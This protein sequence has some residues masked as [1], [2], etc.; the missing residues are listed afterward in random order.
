M[1][2]PHNWTSILV[3]AVAAWLFGAVYYTLL[4]P[5]WIA[6]QGMTVERHKAANASISR[7]AFF[8]PFV[9]SFIAE[10][11]MA[12]VLSGIMV[13]SGF[14]TVRQG[15]IS[16]ALCWFGFVLT[17]V[18][19]NNAYAMRKPMLGVIDALHWLCVLIIIG[20]IVGWLS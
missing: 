12:A 11:V 14:S 19:V 16:G 18:V 13:H 10:V 9:L 5:K 17:T 20:A 3:A 7:T 4:G 8:A 6:A 2:Q 15:A 1:M